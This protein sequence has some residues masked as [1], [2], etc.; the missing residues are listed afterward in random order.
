MLIVNNCQKASVS[1]TASFQGGSVDCGN[2]APGDD[3]NLVAYDQKPHVK[4]TLTVTHTGDQTEF[5]VEDPV[6]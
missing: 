4:V 1:Y 6:L 3:V 2:L 5:I